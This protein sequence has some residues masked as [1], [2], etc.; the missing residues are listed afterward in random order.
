MR[1]LF[2][3]GRFL[4]LI[5]RWRGYWSRKT[6]FNYYAR[7]QYV[8]EIA[9][10]MQRTRESVEE[11][12]IKQLQQMNEIRA[13]ETAER[14]G[15]LA[16]KIH[17]LKGTQAVPGVLDPRVL[18]WDAQKFEYVW[19]N[20][21]RTGISILGVSG[22][23]MTQQDLDFNSEY[24]RYIQ[25][26]VNGHDI[27][28]RPDSPQP[29]VKNPM[30]GPFLPINKLQEKKQAPLRPT[31]RVATDFYDTR[32]FKRE[33]AR[34]EAATRVSARPLIVPRFIDHPHPPF[35]QSGEPYCVEVKRKERKRESSRG[36]RNVLPPIQYTL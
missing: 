23:K 11:Y 16:G 34:V 33:A 36:F 15:R 25:E 21:P 3:K 24:L 8:S 30:Q 29:N 17:H 2:K 18:L 26:N 9:Q 7:K 32:N 1:K 22:T 12:R 10:K 27:K 13:R 28:L 6:R 19:V 31:L 20:V 14:T 5:S 35:S 4:I